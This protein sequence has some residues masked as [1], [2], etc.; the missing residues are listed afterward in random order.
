VSSAEA[1]SPP[2]PDVLP[3][4]G[5]AVEYVG[6]LGALGSFVVRRVGR[7]APRISWAAPP[8][9]DFL[10]A[11]WVGGLILFI[12]VHTWLVALRIAAEVLAWVLCLRGTRFVAP[13]AVFAAAIMP[14]ASHAAAVQPVATGAEFADAVHVLSAAMWAGGILALASLRPPEGWRG[15]E[16]RVLLERFGRV[17]VIAFGV[18]ALTGLLS[19]T[20]HLNELSDLW[21]TTYGAVLVLKVG[22][23]ALMLGLSAL[24]RRGRGSAAAE[25]LVAILVVSATAALA[26]L[27]PPA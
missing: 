3:F 22:G 18:T 27:S 17:A 9:H 5:H 2:P 19:A 10:F 12:G 7:L 14:L 25:A 24:W 23:V 16:A 20:E 26:V 4:A 21:S 6:L 15:E 8:M 11:A 1:S 13:P